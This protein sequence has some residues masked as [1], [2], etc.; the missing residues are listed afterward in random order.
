MIG[1]VKPECKVFSLIE[2]YIVTGRI[3][4]WRSDTLRGLALSTSHAKQVKIECKRAKDL[5]AESLK[6]LDYD[7][8]IHKR[9]IR[10]LDRNFVQA[11]ANIATQIKLAPCEYTWDWL[12]PRPVLQK[13]HLDRVEVLDVA[14]HF[15]ILRPQVAYSHFSEND[16][17][18][19]CII[20]MFPV[21]FRHGGKD[22]ENVPVSKGYVA[23]K[24]HDRNPDYR[25]KPAVEPDNYPFRVPSSSG[26]GH[27]REESKQTRP[28]EPVISSSKIP[29]I[30][31]YAPKDEWDLPSKNS[32]SRAGSG[33]EYGRK[34]ADKSYPTWD[35]SGWVSNT[36]STLEHGRKRAETPHNQW[37]SSPNPPDL[38]GFPISVNSPSSRRKESEG[39]TVASEVADR[40]RR[41]SRT[42]WS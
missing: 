21:L 10:E 38:W 2:S 26:S 11:M 19:D 7:E 17:I 35:Y 15:T 23:V 24:L 3:E 22:K 25:H 31:E 8:N 27:I 32:S 41:E 18:G 13:R 39:S 36:S 34:H 1:A 6:I 4:D 42:F 5:V 9:F 40:F 14:T 29:R 28:D 30:P 12:C 33:P 16:A 20:P 37:H